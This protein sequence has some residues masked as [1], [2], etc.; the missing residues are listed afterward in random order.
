MSECEFCHTHSFQDQF[1]MNPEEIID[2]IYSA[3]PA[4]KELLLT[5][6]RMVARK[7][8]EIL[9]N[10]HPE[11]DLNFT[12]QAAMLHDIGILR[13]DA[14]GILC[15]GSLPYI[16]HGVAGREI[17]DKLGFPRHALVCERHT[18][19]GLT[20]EDIISGN[21]PL[22]RRDMTPQSIEEKAI[23]YADKFFSKSGD[24]TREKSLSEVRKGIAR[25]GEKSLLRFEQLHELFRK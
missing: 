9:E 8:L 1:L 2:Y 12:Y 6:S 21:L 5:H 4:L 7:S 3:E 10:S 20:V 25:F 23:C 18:G 13:T 17:L 19:T 15:R 24:P 14:P 16:C 11:A 22:P